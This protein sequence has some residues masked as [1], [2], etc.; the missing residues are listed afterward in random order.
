MT[1]QRQPHKVSSFL[2]I[3]TALLASFYDNPLS[4]LPKSSGAM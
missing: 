2:G 3:Q 1:N 4:I